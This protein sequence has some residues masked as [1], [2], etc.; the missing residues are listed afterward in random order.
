MLAITS[1]SQ[2]GF[3]KY[4]RKLLESIDNWPGDIVVYYEVSPPDFKH[5]KIEYKN[6]FFIEEAGVPICANFLQYIRDIPL[7]HGQTENGYNY[8]YD[9][10][11]FCRK[12]FA[13]WDILRN[14]TGQ[15]F[16]LDADCIIK[17]PVALSQLE[18]L[19]DEKGLALLGRTGFYTE[20][21]V[22][23]F[24]TRN[25]KFGE[26]LQTYIDF[27]RKGKVFLL[28]RWHDCEMLDWA[29]DLSGISWNNLSPFF[30]FKEQ[31][32]LDEM[33]V[34]PKTKLGEFI[35]HNKGHLK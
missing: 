4:G 26:F 10:W 35:K 33:D 16:W 27:L 14:H 11:K 12:V 8:N 19:F 9:L 3:E 18:E 25:E 13:Q 30:E 29:R 1:F 21:G 24:D 15:A 32:S 7:A 2:S 23:G 5:P 6:L 22:V 31:I 20:T 17:K 34:L 28:P